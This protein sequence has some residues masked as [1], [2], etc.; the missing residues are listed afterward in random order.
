MYWSHS[1][2][3]VNGRESGALAL[4]LVLLSQPHLFPEGP[5]TLKVEVLDLM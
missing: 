3:E 1:L 5:G 2:L 4:G